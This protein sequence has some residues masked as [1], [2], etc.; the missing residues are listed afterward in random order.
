MVKDRIKLA[1]FHQKLIKKENISHK[2]ALLIYEMLHKE[3]ISLGVIN[4]KNVLDGIEV[5]LKIAKAL[6]GLT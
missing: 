4:S 3:A 1:K 6:K 2:K 5:T